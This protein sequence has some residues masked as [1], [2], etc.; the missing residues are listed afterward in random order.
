MTELSNISLEGHLITPSILIDTLFLI[1]YSSIE[2]EAILKP[3]LK[4]VGR[5]TANEEKLLPMEEK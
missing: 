1:Q 4:I 5:D 2:T 3:F